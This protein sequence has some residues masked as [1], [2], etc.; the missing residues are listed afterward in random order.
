M[1]CGSVGR[2]G[3]VTTC[4]KES[5][6]GSEEKILK[7]TVWKEAAKSYAALYLPTF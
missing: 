3:P 2:R 1:L 4:H 5:L 6:Q 7:F